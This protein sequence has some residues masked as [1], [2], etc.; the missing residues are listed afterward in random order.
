MKISEI[1]EVLTKLKN[2][3]GDIEVCKLKHY[4]YLSRIFKDQIIY[5]SKENKIEI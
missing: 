4:D 1:I 3:H 2:K 5:N